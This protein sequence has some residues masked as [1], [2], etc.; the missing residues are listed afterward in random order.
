M[1]RIL[2]VLVLSLLS[3]F[4][5]QRHFN[6]D[7]ETAGVIYSGFITVF[8]LAIVIGRQNDIKANIEKQVS[9]KKL[10]VYQ[11]LVDHLLDFGTAQD[12]ST[13]DQVRTARTMMKSLITWG[14]DDTLKMDKIH[15]RT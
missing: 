1:V 15:C 3:I 12:A 6:L 9:D 7:K 14:S 13:S 8:G 5:A 10:E 11:Q 2:A 4:L